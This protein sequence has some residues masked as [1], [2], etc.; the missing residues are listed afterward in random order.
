M[1]KFQNRYR[2]PSA[3]LATWDYGC[4]GSYFITICTKNR[5]HFFG[6]I[7][8]S[9][10]YLNAI[11]LIADQCWAALPEHFNKITLGEFVI[12]PNHTHGIITIEPDVD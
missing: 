9:E 12:M 11:G 7:N 4:P 3:R 10:M 5:E 2:I 1:Q 6:D 8:N